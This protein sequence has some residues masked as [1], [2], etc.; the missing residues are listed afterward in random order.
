[1]GS[2]KITD[3]S[4]IGSATTSNA[5]T[6]SSGGA[7][8]FASTI[9][10]DISGNATTVT[11]GVYTTSSVTELSDVTSVGSGAIITDEERTKLSGIDTSANVTNADTVSAAGAVMKTG[12]QII[13]GEKEFSSIIIG[14]LSGA[15]ARINESTPANATASGTK[16]DIVFDVSYTYVCVEANTWK[17]SALSTW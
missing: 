1:M 9:I 12:D 8:T 3:G 11:S 5:M 16:G 6:I 2:I 7:V 14:D 13:A 10:G 15:A 4:T 17:R